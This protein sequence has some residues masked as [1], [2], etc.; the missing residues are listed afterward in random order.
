MASPS[1]KR[2]V[3]WRSAARRSPH[4][5]KALARL[6][7]R[8]RA[9]RLEKKLTQEEAAEAAALDTKHYQAIEAGQSNLTIASLLG[10]SRALGVELSYLVEGI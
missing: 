1:R 3:G 5:K 8:L 6:A 10:I 9:I 2:R 4:L 7:R